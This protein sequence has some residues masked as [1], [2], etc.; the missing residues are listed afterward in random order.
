MRLLPT[1]LR[2]D[3]IN[4]SHFVPHKYIAQFWKE[5]HDY[6][7]EP[8]NEMKKILPPLDSWLLGSNIWLFQNSSDPSSRNRQWQLEHSLN[9]FCP[10]EQTVHCQLCPKWPSWQYCLSCQ[11]LFSAEQML[12]RLSE[13]RSQFICPESGS[14][15]IRFNL[16]P[17][18]CLKAS[19]WI[20][21]LWTSQ[22]DLSSLHTLDPTTQLSLDSWQVR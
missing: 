20:S 11:R 16:L 14:L 15:R 8:K 22:Q 17:G 4:K 5:F 7:Q 9:T 12:L 21:G 18:T 19:R 10:L 6:Y 1:C 13:R 3:S 2:F